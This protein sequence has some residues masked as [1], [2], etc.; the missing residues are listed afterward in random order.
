MSKT[1]ELE[2]GSKLYLFNHNALAVNV[3]KRKP[4]IAYNFKGRSFWGYEMGSRP[5]C[6]C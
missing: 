2:S 6:N 4:I 3:I 1:I 5:D